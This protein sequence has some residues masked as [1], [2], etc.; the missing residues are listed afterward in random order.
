MSRL[1]QAITGRSARFEC[2]DLDAGLP[3]HAHQPNSGMEHDIRCEVGAILVYVHPD[4]HHVVR[5]GQTLQVDTTRWHGIV[6]LEVGAVFVN[7]GGVDLGDSS[8][9]VLESP[10]H[11]P[12]WVLAIRA[13][14]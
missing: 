8:S 5:A 3:M 10:H 12:D 2:E 9:T 13:S 11:A 7:T 4:Q 6:P 1:K 14:L